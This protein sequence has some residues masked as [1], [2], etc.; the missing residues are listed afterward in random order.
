MCPMCDLERLLVPL[1]RFSALQRLQGHASCA[2]A[3]AALISGT[4]GSVLALLLQPNKVCL[5]PCKDTFI[6]LLSSSAAHLIRKASE[7]GQM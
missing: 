1:C 5:S 4:E 2:A 3:A 7:A 6:S